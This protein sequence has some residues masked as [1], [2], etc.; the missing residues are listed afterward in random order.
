VLVNVICSLHQITTGSIECGCDGKVALDKLSD[1]DEEADT[2][3]QHFDL[4]SATRAALR[5][6]PIQWTFRHVKGHQDEDPEA[7][8]DR[9][10]FLNIQMDNLAKSYWQEQLHSAAS[11]TTQALAGE[12]W[13]VFLNGRKVHSSL[14]KSIYEEIY[15]NKLAIHW[16]KH[17]RFTQEQCR[18]INWDACEQAMR[19]L[20]ITRRHWVSKH[21]EGMCGVGKWLMK[22]K[23]RDTDACPRCNSPA[24][25]ARH[26]WTCPAA[27]TI[28]IRS[29]GME[30]LDQWMTSSLTSP[31]IR[32]VIN[33]RLSQLFHRLP[34]TPIPNIS[35]KVQ[36]ALGIQDE[37]GWETFFEGCLVQDWE[38]AQDA[39]Y[40]WCK[41][42]KSG[43]RWATS[44]IQKLWDIAWDLW[45]HRIGI[46][47]A[48]ANAAN[49]HNMTLVDQEIRA[50]FRRG[51]IGLSQRDHHLFQSDVH[52]ILAAP[53]QYRRKWLHRADTARARAGRRLITTY[54]AER[55]ALRAWL[56]GTL[57][58]PPEAPSDPSGF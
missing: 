29:A 48:Q 31:D 3:G 5:A 4:L 41:S 10:A 14:T 40:Q 55:Q 35:E 9:W 43:R 34:L 38:A 47:H 42:R 53:V 20:K 8:L 37:I 54:S 7:V 33:T 19:R 18:R 49:L 16:E 13:P 6:S 50:H 36:E 56:Q 46:V 27:T 39:Y 24:E 22:W 58:P 52:D 32:L 15:R 2:A 1:P 12:Y 23:E 44:L 57:P 21:T 51:F 11:T 28:P 26:V 30:R 25:D 45:E 17:E